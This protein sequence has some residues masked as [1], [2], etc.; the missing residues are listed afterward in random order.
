MQAKVKH[1][2]G[3]GAMTTIIARSIRAVGKRADGVL[4]DNKL[5]YKIYLC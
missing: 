3:A 4:S 1:R 5:K 2:N